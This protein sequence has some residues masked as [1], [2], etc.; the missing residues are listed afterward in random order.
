MVLFVTCFVDRRSRMTGK[1][2]RRSG[3][4]GRTPKDDEENKRRHR[5]TVHKVWLQNWKG[6]ANVRARKTLVLLVLLET[7]NIK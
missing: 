3:S 5:K 4:L 1:E 7:R 2:L 6:C